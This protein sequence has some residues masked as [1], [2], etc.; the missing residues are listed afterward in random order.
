[1]KKFISVLLSVLIIAAA[2][3][4]SVTVFAADSEDVPAIAN[5]LGDPENQDPTDPTDPTGD[6]TDPTD[7]TTEPTS[8]TTPTEPSSE[9]TPT[10][11]TEPTYTPEKVTGL[12]ATDVDMSSLT[13]TWSKSKY[14]TKYIVYRSSEDSTGKMGDFKKIMSLKETSLSETSLKAGRFYK[15]KVYAYRVK[16]GVTTK[17]AATQLNI[18]TK[19]KATAKVKVTTRKSE[20]VTLKWS[21]VGLATH[22]VIYR[23][24]E[25]SD[26]SYSQYKIVASLKSSRTSYIDK[27]L[28]PGRFYRY[29]VVVKRA[30]AG[31]TRVSTGKAIKTITNLKAPKKFVNKTATTSTIQL[32]W[33]KVSGASRY[34]ISRKAAGSDDYKVIKSTT[35]TSFKDTGLKSGSDYTYR[36]CAV[37]KVGKYAYKGEYATLSASTSSAGNVSGIKARSYAS[38]ALLTWNDASGADGYEVSIL[39]DSGKYKKV[40]DVSTP[41]YLSGKLTPGKTYKYAVKSY[42][43]SGSTKLYGKTKYANVTIRSQV[44]GSVPSGTYVEVCTETQTLYMVVNDK[45]YLSTPVVTG[46]YGELATTPGWHNVMSKQSPSQLKGEYNG[47]KWDVT[48]SYWL[49]FTADGQGIHDSDWRYSYGGNIYMGDGSHGCVNTPYDKMAKVYNKAFIGMPVI[50]Y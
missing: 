5:A 21:S 16:N 10:E 44:Y 23:S 25:K 48:V 30:K 33:S 7:D 49:G 29:A 31:I 32:A 42:N 38:R 14:A 28:T 13:L 17:S 3:P 40:G 39:K 4:M 47:S 37:R 2:V 19:P 34:D 24:G 43:Y 50:V 36:I 35:N 22:Y 27:G 41:N 8:E 15:Y 12:K 1:M 9:T 46:N 20:S 11:P 45:P 6:A 18:M 26:G